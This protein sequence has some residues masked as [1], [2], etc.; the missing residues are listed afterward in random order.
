MKSY[1]ASSPSIFTKAIISFILFFTFWMSPTD[2]WTQAT[3]CCECEKMVWKIKVT[4]MDGWAPVQNIDYKTYNGEIQLKEKEHN[5]GEFPERENT[6]QYT[7]DEGGLVIRLNDKKISRESGLGGTHSIS[8]PEMTVHISAT[9]AENQ[10]WYKES[11]KCNAPAENVGLQDEDIDFKL[12]NLKEETPYSGGSESHPY[13]KLEKVKKYKHAGS[14]DIINK[15]AGSATWILKPM[16][17]I[18]SNDPTC[19][20]ARCYMPLRVTLIWGNQKVEEENQALKTALLNPQEDLTFTP[21][22]TGETTGEIIKVMVTNP[23]TETIM[24]SIPPSIVPPTG[25]FQGYTI[26]EETTGSLLPGE[27][28][29][30]PLKG[31]C[32]DIHSKPVKD[33]ME[34]TSI[35][36]WI[37]VTEAGPPLQPGTIPPKNSVFEFSK[38]HPGMEHKSGVPVGGTYC[39]YPGTSE[40]FEYTIDIKDHPAEAAP[41]LFESLYYI[42]EAYDSL[43]EEGL[44]E[45]PFSAYP[46]KEKESILQ[47]TYWIYTSILD[48]EPYT[49]NDFENKLIDQYE[50]SSG[51]S[52]KDASKEVQEELKKGTQQFWTTFNLVGEEAKVLLDVEAKT[53]STEPKPVNEMEGAKDLKCQCDSIKLRYRVGYIYEENDSFTLWKFNEEVFKFNG[54]K[55]IAKETQVPGIQF[56]SEKEEPLKDENI[57][58]MD[59]AFP[60]VLLYCSCKEEGKITKEKECDEI[61]GKRTGGDKIF[62]A[63]GSRTTP[64]VYTEKGKLAIEVGKNKTFKKFST[65]D[66]QK[67][68]KEEI[69]KEESARNIKLTETRDSLNRELAEARRNG[70]Q[71]KINQE[72]EA[73]EKFNKDLKEAKKDFKNWKKDKEDA[74]KKR[75][76]A[77]IE[78]RKKYKEGWYKDD[79][80][81]G[82]DFYGLPVYRILDAMNFSMTITITGYCKGEKCGG[83]F[84]GQQCKLDLT[85]NFPKKK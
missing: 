16:I 2:G 67:D 74:L 61:Y 82:E 17:T 41:L 3:N 55:K 24:F 28:A 29:T 11:S 46:L 39:T 70:D 68:M 43:K 7:F 83:D 77:I 49:V 18:E 21:F 60:S 48:D 73:L 71:Q 5:K 79:A 69:D 53:P 50:T 20:S 65:W 4:L 56:I 75:K 26:I 72:K 31:W 66:A 54:E 33:G 12:I 62:D 34:V 84:G 52:F 27:T 30:F 22:G 9:L 42:I 13:Y 85:L 47:Q 58:T 64:F 37:S 51:T 35:N 36:N 15:E 23:T 78:L 80:F 8:E 10:M 59:L 45:T 81:P 14:Y 40:L 25:K 19:H 63:E 1:T 44:I 76:K 32:Y 6:Q 57:L 38:A